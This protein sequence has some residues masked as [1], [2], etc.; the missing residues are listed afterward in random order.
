M[1]NNRCHPRKK[2]LKNKKV[3]LVECPNCEKKFPN[4]K[5]HHEAEH[6]D[7][8]FYGALGG[9]PEP[10]ALEPTPKPTGKIRICKSA[11]SYLFVS[12][13]DFL[14]EGHSMGKQQN[15]WHNGIM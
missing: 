9:K 3:T 4:L 12:A 2:K 13:S 11:V 6:S 10:A 1:F 5:D 7:L 14:P 8:R 15:K